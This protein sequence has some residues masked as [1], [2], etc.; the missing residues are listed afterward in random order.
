MSN[1]ELIDLTKHYRQGKNLIRALD[2]VSL[3]I[4]GGEFLSIVGRSGSG[5][6]ALLAVLGLLLPPTN[7]SVRVDGGDTAR[8]TD[9][10]RAD[11]RGRQIGFIFPESNLR[12]SL[13][14]V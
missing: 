11:P 14:V 2:G 9:G 6:T 7:G 8:L 4:R 13:N 1:I 12:P 5:K 3:T 10:R